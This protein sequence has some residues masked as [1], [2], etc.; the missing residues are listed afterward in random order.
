M[1]YKDLNYKRLEEIFK[2]HGISKLLY[3]TSL[4]EAISL[5]PEYAQ[6]QIKEHYIKEK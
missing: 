4:D 1:I 5:L 6:L 2:E 3:Q